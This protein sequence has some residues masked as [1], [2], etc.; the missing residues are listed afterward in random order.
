VAPSLHERAEDQS[1]DQ[2][3]EQ[4]AQQSNVSDVEPEPADA[5]VRDARIRAAAY[6]LSAERGFAPG[7]EM[8]DW[9]AAE[10]QLDGRG[11]AF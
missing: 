7:Y 5:D 1:T 3:L 11:D 8:D 10:R 2:A 6:A 4:Q 9:L